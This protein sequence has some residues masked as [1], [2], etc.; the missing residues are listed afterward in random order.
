[1]KLQSYIKIVLV[2]IPVLMIGWQVYASNFMTLTPW[3]G[4]GYGMYTESHRT[5]G[6]IQLKND[7]RTI[8]VYPLS[9]ELYEK[10][11]SLDQRS[12]DLHKKEAM[13]FIYF[14][15][16]YF[17]AYKNLEYLKSLVKEGDTLY[18][19]GVEI[20][21]DSKSILQKILFENAI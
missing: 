5:L 11:D 1:M 12:Y 9:D 3:K 21:I 6:L 16:K 2:A 4:G 20:D 18:L 13:L 7:T 17:D 15:Q 19:Q 10:L 8:H 14:P